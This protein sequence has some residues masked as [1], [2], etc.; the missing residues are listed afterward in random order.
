MENRPLGA[1]SPNH[2]A[3]YVVDPPQAGS[4]MRPLYRPL[5]LRARYRDDCKDDASD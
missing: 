5:G 2:S 3:T 4:R 1:A